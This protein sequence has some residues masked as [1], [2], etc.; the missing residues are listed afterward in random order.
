MTIQGFTT[1]DLQVR[2]YLVLSVFAQGGVGKTHFALTAP[3]PIAYFGFDIGG[4]D[5]V[6][7][8]QKAK[9]IGL[10]EKPIVLPA[11]VD[12]DDSEKVKNKCRRVLD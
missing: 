4:E 7:K 12:A 9:Y 8:F 3:G 11:F 10:P 2:D 1:A 6:R 5:P